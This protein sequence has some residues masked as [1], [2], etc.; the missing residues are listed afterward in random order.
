LIN[1]VV[2]ADKRKT[3]AKISVIGSGFS[4]LAAA[5][6]MAENG[7]HV[8]VFEK[9]ESV[10][11]RARKFKTQGFTFDMGPSWYWMPDIFDEYFE[12]FGHKVSDYYN[13]IRLDPSYR[14]FFGIDDTMD[15][16]ANMEDLYRLFEEIEKGSSKKLKKFLQQAQYKYEVGISEF[17]WK[18]GKSITEF[19]DIRVLKS[20]FK[21]QMFSSISKEIRSLF[22]HEKLIQ[23]LEF[24]VLFLGATPQNT[25]ALYSLMNYADLSLGTWYPMGG[26]Y[27]IVEAM[28]ALAISK[29]VEF[30]YK[31]P[32]LSFSVE[33]E[34]ITSLVTNKGK[35]TPDYVIAGADYHHVEQ[36]LLPAKSRQYSEKY[37]DTRTMAPSSL[38][39][40]IGYDTKIPGIKH[41]NLFFD[42]DFDGHAKDIYT[43][44]KWPDKP[45]FYVCCPSKTDPSVAPEGYENVFILMPIAPDLEDNEDIRE[46]YFKL[47]TERFKKLVGFDLSQHIVYKR[48]YCVKDFKADY[49]AFKGNAYGLANTL[50]QTAILKPAIKN[51]KVKNLYFTGQL[52]TPGPGVPPS[53]ISGQMVAQELIKELNLK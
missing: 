30:N 53:L 27:K 23:L 7:H 41:H 19:M 52:T 34:S 20:V 49:H 8:T 40:Y 5:T 45:L 44:P 47:I 25:P 36:H 6:V 39:F 11:G 37:W 24:P 35:Y 14:I 9:N 46:K 2:I 3:V 17:V 50:R 10:G 48:S 4:S 16:P 26:M 51:K 43:V 1:C 38:L 33:D 12:R 21:L 15:I 32:A 28:E 29:G 18:P 22:K 42:E 13:L 31:E